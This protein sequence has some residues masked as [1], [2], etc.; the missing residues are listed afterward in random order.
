MT[1][2]GLP[3]DCSR[4]V[5]VPVVTDR[6]V[7]L[8]AAPTISAEG[9]VA[10][11][12]C[13]QDISL[14]GIP[15]SRRWYVVHTQPKNEMRAVENLNRQGFRIFCPRER[16]KVRHARKTTEVM[17]PL[18]PCYVFVQLDRSIDLWRSINGTRGV[19]RLIAN[20]DEPIAVP[21]G[22]VE[23]LQRRMGADGVMDLA[24]QLKT[25]DQ[26]TIAEGPFAAMTGT[27][28]NLDAAGRVQILLDLLGQAVRVSVASRAISRAQ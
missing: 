6:S 20:G 1:S 26:V 19:I 21:K 9:C 7:N 28:Q 17:A 3:S 4:L 22:V 2:F 13:I 18:F 24:E 10:D 27:L 14:G 11:P 23:N 12:H 16:R 5:A 8:G 15:D 25:G